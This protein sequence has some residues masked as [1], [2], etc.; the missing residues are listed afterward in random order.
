MKHQRKRKRVQSYFHWKRLGKITIKSQSV[1]IVHDVNYNYSVNI[2]QKHY[3]RNYKWDLGP[4]DQNFSNTPCKLTFHTHVLDPHVLPHQQDLVHEEE[5]EARSHASMV[6]QR[7]TK[8]HSE[9][10]PQTDPND[11]MVPS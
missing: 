10:P 8:P 6:N 1:Q 9:L 4:S 5:N 7:W 11:K 2:K 3:L